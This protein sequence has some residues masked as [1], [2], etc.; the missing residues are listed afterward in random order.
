MTGTQSGTNR[1]GAD[2][3]DYRWSSTPDAESL[4][5]K[6]IAQDAAP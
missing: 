5:Q 1:R 3:R 4:T 2:N 6:V